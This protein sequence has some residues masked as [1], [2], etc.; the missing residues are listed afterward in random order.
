[1]DTG[2]AAPTFLGADF[3]SGDRA[4]SAVAHQSIRGLEMD[5][6]VWEEIAQMP[7]RELMVLSSPQLLVMNKGALA[8]KLFDTSAAANLGNSLNHSLDAI[9]YLV[10]NAGV[11]NLAGEARNL[12][13][14]P[15]TPPGLTPEQHAA[16]LAIHDLL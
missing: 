10:L 11:D 15:A 13:D 12:P 5:M 9:R 6:A 16:H 7:E 4:A 1:M 3:G 2:R 14:P 8:P